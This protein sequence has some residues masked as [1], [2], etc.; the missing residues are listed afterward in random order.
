VQTLT[1]RSDSVLTV[2][3]R[4]PYHTEMEYVV[5]AHNATKVCVPPAE[6]TGCTWACNYLLSLLLP[7]PSGMGCF[8]LGTPRVFD[9]QFRGGSPI[10]GI[11]RRLAVEFIRS[12][13]V[14]HHCRPLPR[15]GIRNQRVLH[16]SVVRSV[17]WSN[18][19]AISALL[20]ALWWQTERLKP[21][22]KSMAVAH[23][24]QSAF[25]RLLRS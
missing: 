8:E 13:H 16:V 22:R 2:P 1:G 25:T 15:S 14:S 18:G 7:G 4:L 21:L 6:Y 10:C 12:R 11:R 3:W 20:C 23:T 17:W 19:W 24:G 5:P 9:Q